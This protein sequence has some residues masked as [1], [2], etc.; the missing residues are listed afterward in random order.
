M[1]AA[2]YQVDVDDWHAAV[3]DT[4]AYEQL[5]QEDPQL[6]DVLARLTLQKHVL[7]NADARHAVKIFKQLGVTDCFQVNAYR[8]LTGISGACEL[9][10]WIDW[11]G[12]RQI[13]AQVQAGQG[14]YLCCRSS[15]K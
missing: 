11:H 6:R 1:Q 4:L 7:T 9:L 2:G 13:V 12:G 3:H 14:S 15:I 8:K 10:V 5:L